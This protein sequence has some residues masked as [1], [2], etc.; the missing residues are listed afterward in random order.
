MPRSCA[1]YYLYDIIHTHNMGIQFLLHSLQSDLEHQMKT[2]QDIIVKSTVTGNNSIPLGKS[3][4]YCTY[5]KS[6]TLQVSHTLGCIENASSE[7]MYMYMFIFNCRPTDA[8]RCVLVPSLVTLGYPVHRPFP[9]QSL[10]FPR[11]HLHR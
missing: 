5:K 9:G 11:I 2:L 8:K 4:V 7:S 10:L 3:K 1:V 6:S